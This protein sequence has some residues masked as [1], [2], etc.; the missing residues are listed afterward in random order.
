MSQRN[1]GYLLTSII[2]RIV[3]AQGL[4][5][6][7]V[8]EPCLPLSLPLQVEH[9]RSLLSLLPLHFRGEAGVSEHEF[10]RREPNVAP[11]RGEV[12]GLIVPNIQRVHRSEVGE[13]PRAVEDVLWWRFLFLGLD[14]DCVGQAVHLLA[15]VSVQL[16]VRLI[17][18]GGVFRSFKQ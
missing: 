8:L 14:V 13:R 10:L 9:E 4:L 17:V 3:L 15:H 18:Q 5:G 1:L 2:F 12:L 11:L 7:L 6:E 16:S